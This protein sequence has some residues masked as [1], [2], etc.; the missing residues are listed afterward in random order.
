MK[1]T[2]LQKTMPGVETLFPHRTALRAWIMFR[3]GTPRYAAIWGKQEAMF[4]GQVVAAK[5]QGGGQ[6]FVF[7]RS[8]RHA[9]LPA[10]GSTY[11][12]ISKRNCNIYCNICAWVSTTVVLCVHIMAS[13]LCSCGLESTCGE[14]PLCKTPALKWGASISQ[15]QR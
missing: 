4:S 11:W 6:C 2:A 14:K 9:E 12:Q 8:Q 15:R 1:G 5:T 3:G 10:R 7:I 13:G